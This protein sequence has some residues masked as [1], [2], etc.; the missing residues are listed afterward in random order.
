MNPRAKD[1]IIVRVGTLAV[2]TRVGLVSIP[3]CSVFRRIRS[4]RGGGGVERGG[5]LA[6]PLVGARCPGLAMQA[7]P[8]LRDRR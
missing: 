6:S 4:R 1:L 5:M 7:S 2:L 8:P 3:V